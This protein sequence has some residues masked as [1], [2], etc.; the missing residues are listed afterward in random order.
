V[1]AR[2][3]PV[4]TKGF[5]EVANLMKPPGS[6]LRPAMAVRVL[7]GQLRARGILLRQRA[8]RIAL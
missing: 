1:A 4:L 5:L 3:D 6:I 7:L 2:H 8:E